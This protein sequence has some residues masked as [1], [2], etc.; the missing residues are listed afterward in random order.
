MGGPPP[1]VPFDER[2]KRMTDA[3]H[4]IRQSAAAKAA[5]AGVDHNRGSRKRERAVHTREPK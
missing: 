4:A 3:L 5:T 2:A 1:V